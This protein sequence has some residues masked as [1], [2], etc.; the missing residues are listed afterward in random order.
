[1]KSKDIVFTSRDK[2]ELVTRDLRE[3]GPREVLCK[4]EMSLISQGTEM[5]C[6]RAV[7]DPLTNWYAWV[8]YPFTPGYSMTGTVVESGSEVKEYKPGDRGVTFAPHTQY[9]IE[10]VDNNEWLL[11]I[12]D[13]L[14]FA[15]AT[16]M[17][18]GGVITQ[19]CARR[20]DLRL[21]D[22]V[23]IIGLGMLGQLITQY[24]N[25]MGAGKII[26]IDLNS[27]RLELAKKSGATHVLAA[28]AEAARE[29]VSEITDGRF[30]DIIYDVTGLPHV[31]SSATRLVCKMGKVMMAGDN[32]EPSK[33]FLGP[34]FLSDSLNLISTHDHAG[35]DQ[36][37]WNK[38][39]M[40]QFFF[41]MLLAGRMNV[42][43]LNTDYF[44]PEEAPK[45]YKWLGDEKPDTVGILFD[46][47]RL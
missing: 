2:V 27:K 33:Q 30:L 24:I 3:I 22:N 36:A 26:A 37:N 15:E 4:A 21:G 46:W 41:E 31:L 39:R 7:M 20:A 35:L 12:P 38:I 18:V 45:V 44:S 42:K 11:K 23:G 43:Q 14:S 5:R 34:N 6:L 16:W 1:M 9:F 40:S 29:S 28:D 13:Q 19:I 25:L 32:T 17:A 47:N 8:K 10:S